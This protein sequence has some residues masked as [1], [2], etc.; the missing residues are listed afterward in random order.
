MFYNENMETLLEEI[1]N[2]KLVLG[3]FKALSN[4]LRLDIVQS[5]SKSPKYVNELQEE[6]SNYDPTSI[7]KQLAV[8][9]NSGIVDSVREG[10]KIKYYLKLDCVGKMIMCIDSH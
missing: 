5:L 3:V 6:F 1:K 10:K 9:K 7:S 2:K 4:E 8:L